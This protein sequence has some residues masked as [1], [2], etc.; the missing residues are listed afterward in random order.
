MSHHDL[1]EHSGPEDAPGNQHPGAPQGVAIIGMACRFPDADTPARFWSNLVDGRESITREDGGDATSA[2][3]IRA[4]STL[5]GIDGFDA[6][7]FGYSPREAALLDPQHRLFLEVCWEAL[8][9]GGSAGQ[10]R[11][12]D[13]GVYGGCGTSLYLMN[14]LSGQASK[15]LPNFLDSAE[16]LQ[17]AMAAE[18]DYLTSRV[19]YKLDLGGPSVNVQAA[20]ATSLYAVHLA[21]QALLAGEC[22]LALAGGAHVPV[23]QIDG[24]QPEPGLV[25]SQDGHCRAF[26]ARATGTVFGSGVGA[27]LLKP[28]D[29]ALADGDRVYA[30]IRGTAVNNDGSGKPG[31]SAP[32]IAGQAAVI[33]QALAAAD[34]EP[35][36]ISYVEAHGTATP[37]GDPIEVAAL[38]DAFRGVPPRSC[39]LG[40][41]KT[42]IGHLSWAAGVAGIIKVALALRHRTLPASL[43]F[44]EPNPAIDF[45]GSPFFVQSG[46]TDW[47]DRGGP[48]RAGVSAFGLGGMN[49]HAVLEEAPPAPAERAGHA[50]GAVSGTQVLPISGR[51]EPAL[52][53]LAAR[54]SQALLDDTAPDLVDAAYSLGSGRAHFAH[55][56]AVVGSDRK[57]LAALLDAVASGQGDVTDEFDGEIGLVSGRVRGGS[58]RVAALY[59]GQGAEYLEACRDLYLAEPAFRAF[60][61]RTDPRFLEHTGHR[62]SEFLYQDAARRGMRITDVRMAQPVVYALQVALLELW[63]G[64]GVEP[65]VHLGHSLGEYAAAHGA[66]VFDFETGLYLVS[67]RAKLLGTL[68]ESGAMATVFAGEPTV[69]ELLEGADRVGV[70]AINAPGSTVISGD[71]DALRAV[72]TAARKRGIKCKELPIG[73]AGHS[74]QMDAILDDY[75]AVLDSVELRP[76]TRPIISTLTGAPIGEEMATTGY[77]RRQLRHPVLFLEATRACGDP[78]VFLELGLGNTL[79]N[80]TRM[81]QGD[82]GGTEPTCKDRVSDLA[83]FTSAI[84]RVGAGGS[85]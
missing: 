48:L 51:T 32:S 65:D 64:W 3:W 9:D 21:C 7:F 66:G 76:P 25:M 61:D 47:P 68:P 6:E 70:A 1:S 74:A 78:D 18:R 79:V 27:V 59:S 39:A 15:E 24:Y 52:R 41:V 84:R 23:P 35:G 5:E 33:R 82:G 16:D 10:R 73:V 72:V 28:L 4:R 54:M 69:R 60:V 85:A 29:R 49:A 20:C 40:S 31:F 12:D 58:P 55:R 8:E 42:N 83:E 63:R 2:G 62:L 46:T 19:A 45:A 80:L 17:L 57:T 37:T 75:S 36:T 26:D 44:E 13:I 22:D 56:A 34:V 53:D 11:T 67:Q 81:A 50:P 30:V 77:W 38:T 71:R 14:N 43:H